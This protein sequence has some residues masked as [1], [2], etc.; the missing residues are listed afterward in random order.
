[1]MRRVWIIPVG[2]LASACASQELVHFGGT[3]NPVERPSQTVACRQAQ[4]R[5]DAIERRG[6]DFPSDLVYY[7]FI[8]Q[9]TNIRAVVMSYDVTE[10]GTTG[11][12]RY[13]GPISDLDNGTN[14]DATLP[15][16]RAIADWTFAW[17]D[18]PGA[19]F[20]TGCTARFDFTLRQ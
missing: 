11:N 13:G 1:M 16:A 12:I 15:A 14:R 19:R 18:G 5:L 4:P 9:S 8:N 2:L 17:S 10:D 3:L 7:L 20:A 6:P